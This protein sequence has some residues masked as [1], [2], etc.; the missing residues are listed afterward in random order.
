MAT[1]TE[2]IGYIVQNTDNQDSELNNL[3]YNAVKKIF[4]TVEEI[5][6]I[7]DD[8]DYSDEDEEEV[9]QES[10]TKTFTIEIGDMTED[11]IDEHIKSLT[12]K[13]KDK[14]KIEEVEEVNYFSLS[15]VQ[16]RAHQRSGKI[17]KKK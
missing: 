9:K 7:D 13:F 1:K 16:R 11:E 12:K 5:E 3:N 10:T 6:N 17:P 14:I 4:N 15:P 8:L 2:M